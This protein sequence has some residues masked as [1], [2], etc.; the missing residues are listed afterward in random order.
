MYARVY[1]DKCGAWLCAGMGGKRPVGLQAIGD[2]LC[3]ICIGMQEVLFLFLFDCL[4]RI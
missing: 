4:N 2:E 3:N 1:P